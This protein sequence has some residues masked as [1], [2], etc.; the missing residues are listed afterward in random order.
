M[1]TLILIELVGLSGAGDAV[2]I[3]TLELHEGKPRYTTY[4][5][6]S[7]LVSVPGG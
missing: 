1:I 2:A 4:E 6:R 3:R 7:T 5:S